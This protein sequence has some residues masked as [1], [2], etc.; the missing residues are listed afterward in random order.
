VIY[1]PINQKEP[2]KRLTVST[3][4]PRKPSKPPL[5]RKQEFEQIYLKYQK[6]YESILKQYDVKARV[7]DGEFE[8]FLFG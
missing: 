4:L 1:P 7:D 5:T 3:Q 6:S 8:R 2:A